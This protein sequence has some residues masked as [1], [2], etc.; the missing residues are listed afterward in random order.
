ME[1]TNAIFDI[2]Q[3]IGAIFLLPAFTSYIKRWVPERF[4]SMLPLALGA[5]ANI[6]YGLSQGYDFWTALIQGLGI[7]AV[8][9]GTRNAVVKTVLNK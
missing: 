5:V 4:I 2:Y 3:L 8:A 6:F 7:G 9:S 1:E